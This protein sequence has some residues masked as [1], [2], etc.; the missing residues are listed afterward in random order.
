MKKISL[1]LSAV[2]L[3]GFAIA[4]NQIANLR[5]AASLTET[6][7][8]PRM[9]LEVNNDVRLSRDYPMAP[10]I[11][12]HKTE[13]YQVDLNANKCL[14]CHNR[15]QVTA[16]QA[17]MISVTHFMDR[18]GNFLADV[19][20]NRYFCSQCHVSQLDVAPLIANEFISIDI[21]LKRPPSY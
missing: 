13:G 3:L 10:P 18:D 9:A 14:A 7:V 17:P 5:G 6:N 4:E 16:S 8:A 15:Q 11:I 1:L 19:S 2:L 21:L 20:P 12:P